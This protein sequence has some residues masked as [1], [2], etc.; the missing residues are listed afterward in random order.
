MGIMNTLR[1]KNFRCLEDTGDIEIRPLTFLVGANSSG[2]SSFLKFFPL[3]RQ[4]VRVRKKGV[5][6]WNYH[7]V[8]LRDFRN[9][10]REGADNISVDFVLGSLPLRG[11]SH[12]SAGR[13][14][15]G[16]RVSF[17]IEALEEHYDFMRRIKLHYQD[18]E[19]DIDFEPNGITSVFVNG[20]CMN[21]LYPLESIII[22]SQGTGVIPGL[23]FNSEKDITSHPA[24]NFAAMRRI[25]Q[26]HFSSA[27]MA[28]ARIRNALNMVLFSKKELE[29]YIKDEWSLKLKKID[30]DSLNNLMLYQNVGYILFSLNE[31]ISE[32]ANSIEYIRPLRATIDRYYRF[33]NYAIDE[34]ESNGENLAMYL[35]NLMPSQKSRLDMWTLRMFGF[36]I[37]V[38]AHEGHIELG[39]SEGE[40]GIFHNL[41][42]VGFG[43]TQLLPIIVLIWKAVYM[44]PVRGFGSRKTA[45]KIIVIEQPELHLHPRMQMLFADML[46][47]V[48]QTTEKGKFRFIIET[49]SE[50]IINRVGELISL[51]NKFSQEDVNV[52]LFQKGEQGSSVTIASYDED[53]YLTNWPV[54]FF[55][56]YAD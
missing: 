20:K 18:Q 45:K 17:E 4:S 44:G 30:I 31:C 9:T 21:E 25:V 54:G 16:L 33:Q 43:Y 7:D 8:D 35:Y 2:K 40:N 48:L 23:W 26:D 38:N 46:V 32:Y 10:V 52:V 24:Y 3:L 47:K 13:E 36:K 28:A 19:I 12:I 50:T 49:H 11:R 15:T 5:F 39:I 34:I 55:S 22:A 1:L 29:D 51:E 53:G 6:L 37:L 27:Q 42:D 41:V 14:V 56:G